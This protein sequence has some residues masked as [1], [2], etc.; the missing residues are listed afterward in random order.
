[1]SRRAVLAGAGGA[2]AAGLLAA[3]AGDGTIAE[4]ADLDHVKVNLISQ[5]P[6]NVWTGTVGSK[7]VNVT[8]YGRAHAK[9]T[10]AGKTVSAHWTVSGNS[11]HKCTA[12][13]D[14]NLGD[15][16]SSIVGH[17]KLAPGFLFD[18][19]TIS[20]KLGGKVLSAEAHRV[21]GKTTSTVEVTGSLGTVRFKLHGSVGGGLSHGHVTGTVGGKPVALSLSFGTDTRNITG[22]WSGPVDLLALTAGALVYFG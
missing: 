18:K 16:S 14:G 19:G 22:T 5:A 3:L 1:V 17:F 21:P 7:S 2:L 13:L 12:K 4:A 11:D 6:T 8:D 20:G 9:G 15:G 10:F